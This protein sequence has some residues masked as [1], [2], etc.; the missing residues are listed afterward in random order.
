MNDNEI[1]DVEVHEEV[2]ETFESEIELSD[3]EIDTLLV[4]LKEKFNISKAS[5]EE[6][7]AIARTIALHSKEYLDSDTYLWVFYIYACKY[8]R[9]GKKNAE[10][11]CYMR[12]KTVLD[13]EKGKSKKPEA[14]SFLENTLPKEVVIKADE[15]TE[16]VNVHIQG[17]KKTFLM[18]VAV[19]VVIFFLVM[20]FLLKMDLLITLLFSVGLLIVNFLTTYRGLSSKFIKNQTVASRDHCDDEEL[21]DFDLPVFMS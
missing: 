18:I 13:A 9:E 12:L 14:L 2:L 17:I 1:L 19:M 8:K 21:L 20:H 11:Y 5:N 4:Q 3:E 7:E 10:R 15:E 6:I 16:F